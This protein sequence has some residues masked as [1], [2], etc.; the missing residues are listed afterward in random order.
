MRWV[1][2]NFAPGA[3]VS[4]VLLI[5]GAVAGEVYLRATTPFAGTTWPERFDAG[6]G[7]TLVPGAEVLSTNNLDYWTRQR[8]NS[9]GFLDREPVAPADRPGSC[10]MVFLGD[11]MVEAV[12][13]DMEQ[14]LQAVLEPLAAARLP[15]LKVTTSAFGQS[16]T[17][18]INQL[19]FYD[20]FARQQKPKIVVLVAVKNDLADNSLVLQAINRGRDPDH[21]PRVFA[22]RSAEGTFAL[23]PVDPEWPKYLLIPQ[24]EAEP[25]GLADRL[26]SWLRDRS[27]VF[28][29]VADVAWRVSLLVRREIYGSASVLAG[30]HPIVRH[31]RILAARPEYA[32]VLE[33]WEPEQRPAIDEVFFEPELPRVF[34]EAIELT[35]FA[36]DAFLERTRR[37]GAH[38]LILAS[39]TL[40]REDGADGA[41]RIIA[42]LAA[43]RGIPVIDQHAFIKA[44]GGRMQDARFLGD[45]HWSP[46][47]HRWAAEAVLAYLEAHQELCR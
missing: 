40:R 27:L 26:S 14:K 11:S 3:G 18:Q 24:A 32:Y 15:A 9:L 36:L 25:P 46:K 12:Q 1:W 7:F 43:Q 39:H 31:A 6:V 22:R 17:G 2:D 30:S 20:H 33:D 5:L 42:D 10:H 29:R 44:Q 23:T 16:D 28:R 38:L 34:R 8:A 41:F 21:M 45:G 4:L 37:D 35:G 13:V 19:A 47:G